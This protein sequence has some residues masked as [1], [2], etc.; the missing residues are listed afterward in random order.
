MRHKTDYRP[1]IDGLRAIAV[2]AV[3]L[4][5]LDIEVFSG[6]FVGVD[7]FFVISGF[8]I[9]SIIAAKAEAG[10]FSFRDF[11]LGRVRRIIPPL[12][13]TVAVTFIA[14]AFILT[15]DDFQRFSRSAVAA[16]ASASNIVFYLEAGYWDTASELKPLLHTWSLGGVEE[17]FYLVWPA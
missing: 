9:S 13:A 7:V 5:H 11:Y 14:S 16:L 15:P 10:R 8:L 2:L 4:F 3:V 17:Q 12:V 1:D 6:G